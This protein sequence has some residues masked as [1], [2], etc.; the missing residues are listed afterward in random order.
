MQ[1]TIQTRQRGALWA[2]ALGAV[3]AFALVQAP[4]ASAAKLAGGNTT[5]SI[6]KGVADALQSN[7]I[8]VAP[9]KPGE[10]T[11]KGVAFPITG[12]DLKTGKKV[13]GK[14][15]HSGGLRFSGGGSSL[16]L[17]DF[18]VALG[19]KNTL[20]AK[21]GKAKVKVFSLELAKAKVGKKGID[22]TINGVRAEL[23]NAAAEALNATFDTDLFAKGLV[24]GKAAIK[25]T[26]L[27]AAVAAKGQT[28]LAVDPAT[29]GALGGLGIAVAPISPATAGTAGIAFPI[30][31]GKLNTETLAGNI[32]HSGGLRL[33]K[34][35]TTVDLTDFIIQI[36]SNPDLT[37]QVGSSRVSILNL[38]LSQAQIQKGGTKVTITG[39]K[40]TLTQDAAT[41][42]NG[43]FATTAFTAGLLLGTATVDATLE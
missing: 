24:V 8:K 3:L 40:A 23:T 10:V 33:T 41:A 1:A 37:A 32:T 22:T 25:A 21:A 5:L 6:N 31:G 35:S 4:G 18:R 7:G 20:V 38:D 29:A 26:P 28:T 13:E 36:D 12:G 43:A 17:T 11:K 27:E 42:L 15:N 19:K 2:M 34:H 16:E 30:T 9:L 14:I 39:A